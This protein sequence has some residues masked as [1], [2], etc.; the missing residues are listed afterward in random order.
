MLADAEIWVHDYETRD[1]LAAPSATFVL[2]SEVVTPMAWGVVAFA[3]TD[4]A[5]ELADDIGGTV[6]DWDELVA[7]SSVE[8]LF[9][10]QLHDHDPEADS[11][12]D[13]EADSDHDATDNTTDHPS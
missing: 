13:S 1:V 10:A 9:P 2:S 5:H 11:D 6:V 12:H 4:H 3:S 7:R 8:G